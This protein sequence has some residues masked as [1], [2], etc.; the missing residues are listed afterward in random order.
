MFH[1]SW[2]V[3]SEDA[4][5]LWKYELEMLKCFVDINWKSLGIPMNEQ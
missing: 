1:A 3:Y 4:D 2:S 5:L